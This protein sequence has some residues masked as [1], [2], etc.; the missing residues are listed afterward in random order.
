MPI[1]KSVGPGLVLG[2][3]SF[4]IVGAFLC[5]SGCGVLNFSDRSSSVSLVQGGERNNKSS[6]TESEVEHLN[7]LA[8]K[9]SQ[10]Y[11]E[12]KSLQFVQE[13]RRSVRKSDG[14]EENLMRVSVV[15]FMEPTRLRSE[16]SNENRDPIAV[17]LLNKG[18]ITEF[19]ERTVFNNVPSWKRLVYESPSIEGGD[20]FQFQTPYSSL[21]GINTRTWIGPH[22]SFSNFL[23]E[24]ILLANFICEVN[25]YGIYCT[26]TSTES[27]D[28]LRADW[29]W[30]DQRGVL[31]RWTTKQGN[32]FTTRNFTEISIDQLIPPDL[33]FRDPEARPEPEFFGQLA[34]NR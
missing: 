28:G 8:A 20:A 30:F 18:K 16:V 31:V 7:E 10:R 19:G 22:S 34:L 13:V 6:L 25:D 17:F 26:L 29:L 4:V 27:E 5:N 23:A 32:F 3:L 11:R 14:K 15:S 12:M 2:F 21:Y 9:V 24:R 1:S 33:W